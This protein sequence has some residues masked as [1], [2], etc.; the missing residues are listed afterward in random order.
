MGFVTG[1][2]S[3][4]WVWSLPG[5]GRHL[6]K[7]GRLSK[8]VHMERRFGECRMELDAI[9][10]TDRQSMAEISSTLSLKMQ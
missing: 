5:V 10:E 7:P 2:K 1:D 8:I 6:A 4:P 3:A 9:L